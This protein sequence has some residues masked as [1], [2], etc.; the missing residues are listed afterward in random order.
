MDTEKE[1][2]HDT[3]M[4]DVQDTQD[5]QDD[6]CTYFHCKY[7]L[8]ARTEGL[9]RN[10]MDHI[11][12][13]HN[14]TPV[15]FKC[16]Y[17]GV[18]VTFKRDPGAN[19][20]FRCQCQKGVVLRSSVKRH[21]ERCKV[22]KKNAIDRFEKAKKEK[23]LLQKVVIPVVAPKPAP[24]TPIRLPRLLSI[25]RRTAPTFPGSK[26]TKP[27]MLESVSQLYQLAT[28]ERQTPEPTL[29]GNKEVSTNSQPTSRMEFV[30]RVSRRTTAERQTP[31][32]TMER[33]NETSTSSQPPSRMEFVSRRTT[34]ERQ[35][36]NLTS[37]RNEVTSSSP[38]FRR[39]DVASPNPTFQRNEIATPSP[40]PYR[41][42]LYDSEA[43]D[44]EGLELE[45]FELDMACPDEMQQSNGEGSS[46]SWS[47]NRRDEA[48]S[49]V[50]ESKGKGKETEVTDLMQ[51]KKILD[52]QAALIKE[53]QEK[54]Y[55]LENH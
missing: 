29:E 7:N 15:E 38:T 25:K 13:Y 40:Q 42:T 27:F 11:L 9:T 5:K 46:T 10:D 1:S 16:K 36:P 45:D 34:S 4:E 8:L 52:E 51:L 17:T 39:N 22:A 47:A 37:R 3:R 32:P 23:S 48:D 24:F 49:V 41:R 20:L 44:L 55:R 30:S 50:M 14:D 6:E 2:A 18:K 26:V 33:N 12:R 35:T 19:M 28:A 21:Y 53:L 43:L 54:V 31:D